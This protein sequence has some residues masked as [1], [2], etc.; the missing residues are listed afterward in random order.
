MQNLTEPFEAESRER[1]RV[2][3]DSRGVGAKGKCG[4]RSKKHFTFGMRK[5]TIWALKGQLYHCRSLM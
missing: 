4:G 2:G 1:M 5:S 3:E